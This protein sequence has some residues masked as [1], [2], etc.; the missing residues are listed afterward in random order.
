MQPARPAVPLDFPVGGLDVSTAFEAQ[1]PQ[2]TPEAVNVR[3]Y[4]SATQRL[5]GGARPGLA[6]FVAPQVPSGSHLIQCLDTV[7]WASTSALLDSADAPDGSTMDDPST[8]SRNPGRTV[9]VGGSGRQPNRH[10]G[11]QTH[12]IRFV[13][14][15]SATVTSASSSA[16]PTFTVPFSNNVSAGSLLIF[17]GTITGNLESRWL[18]DSLGNTYTAIGA[19]GDLG[20]VWWCVSQA[21]GPCTVTY[22][23]G[24]G[25]VTTAATTGVVLEYSGVAASPFDGSSQ[26]QDFISSAATWTTGAVTTLGTK[27]LML[28]VFAELYFPLPWGTFTPGVDQNVGNHKSFTKRVDAQSANPALI[29]EYF[30]IRVIDFIGTATDPSGSQEFTA[31]GSDPSGG[32]SYQ[33]VGAS[34]QPS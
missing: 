12:H 9:R 33:A 34:F 21:S 17:T 19:F 23:L 14:Q 16:G 13:Q 4:E 26:N 30:A 29:G 10:A 1:P 7:V 28:A 3:G 31:T 20:K 6:K 27:E 11:N 8:G 22:D 5:K 15:N 32:D 24:A 2:T 18:S 25:Q